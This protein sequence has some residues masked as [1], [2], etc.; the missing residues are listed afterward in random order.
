MPGQLCKVKQPLLPEHMKHGAL[1]AQHMPEEL[2]TT[3][4]AM[5][6]L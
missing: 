2:V 6:I 5:E 1:Q 3:A 4:K